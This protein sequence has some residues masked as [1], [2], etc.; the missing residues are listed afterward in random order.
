MKKT[1]IIYV[2]FITLYVKNFI[3]SIIFTIMGQFSKICL[4][5]KNLCD[6][7][8]PQYYGGQEKRTKSSAGT[9]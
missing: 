4:Y 5:F 2:T 6:I 9:V 3:F 8:L 7:I 1:H